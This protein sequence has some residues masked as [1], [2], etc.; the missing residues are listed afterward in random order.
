MNPITRRNNILAILKTAEQPMAGSE[1]A[2]RLSVSRQIIVQDISLL[3]AGGEQILA[4]PQGYLLMRALTTT[5]YRKTFAT[6]HTFEEMLQELEIIVDAGGRVLDVIV[7]HPVYG[8]LRGMLMLG[9]RRDIASFISN[10]KASNS[11]PLSALTHGVHLHT[12]EAASEE[13]FGHIERELDRAGLL[14]RQ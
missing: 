4:T 14:L 8:E 9:S 2:A 7:E 1:L 13:V 12:V 10:I 3:R 11:K 6:C 5:P